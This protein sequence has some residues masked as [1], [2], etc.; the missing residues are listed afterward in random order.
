VAPEIA[1]EAA[2]HVR[3]QSDTI[4]SQP[5]PMAAWPKVATRYLLCR[6]DRLFPAEFQRKMVRER[7]GLTPDEMPGGHLPALA[8]PHELVR[9]LEEYWAEVE[10]VERA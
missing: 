10:T 3:H 9:R 8:H 5:W 6:D 4:F 7:L 2:T 1:A